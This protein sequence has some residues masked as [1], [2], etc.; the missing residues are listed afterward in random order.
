MTTPLYKFSQ[1]E[2]YT[3]AET[4]LNSLE[5]HLAEFSNYKP[6]YDAA[7]ITSGRDYLL[8]TRNLPDAQAR[9]AIAEVA[10]IELSELNTTCL[11]LFQTLKRYI[12]DAFPPQ[13]HKPQFEAA[14][15]QYYLK[16]SQQNWDSTKGLITAASQFIANNAPVL[17][18]NNNMPLVFQMEFDAKK[19]LFETKHQE[20]LQAEEQAQ[21]QTEQK[22]TANNKLYEGLISFCLDGQEIFR[23]NEAIR[24][25]FIIADLLYLASGAGTA[26]VRGTITDSATNQPLEGVIVTD[27]ESGKTATTDNDGKYIITQ[28]AAGSRPIT[29]AKDNYVSQTIQQQVNTGTVGTLNIQMQQTS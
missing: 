25:Q 6:K 22:I 11:N 15:Q 7:F 29:C 1:Q 23:N 20:F 17:T 26:G 21:I 19:T 5:Q 9:G 16:A 18:A 14:G 28:L 3:I 4:A 24:K 12:S 13:Q 27:T 8:Q 2:L 10:R